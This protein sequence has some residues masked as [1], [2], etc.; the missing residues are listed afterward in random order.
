[1]ASPSGSPTLVDRTRCE[2]V[3]G[4]EMARPRPTPLTPGQLD[5]LRWEYE[6]RYSQLRTRESSTL[7]FAGLAA[8]ASLLVFA[9]TFPLGGYPVQL[10]LGF[11]G[12]SFGLLGA[13]YREATIRMEI[14]EF[15]NLAEIGEVL[16]QS[17]G[18][19]HQPRIQEMLNRLNTVQPWQKTRASAIRLY[20]YLPV[21]VWLFY[22][23]VGP[24][25]SWPVYWYLVTY[26]YFPYA[27]IPL[28]LAILAARF[29][30][31]KELKSRE[32]SSGQR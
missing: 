22:M 31:R 3:E 23:A 8:S 28:I 25:W 11:L 10:L 12:L 18:I 17:A 16:R 32:S 14:Q 27:A 21:V 5:F 19:S 6:R 7:A 30:T 13:V 4:D 9:L 26:T 24:P 1:M 15:N 2:A 29:A 20:S